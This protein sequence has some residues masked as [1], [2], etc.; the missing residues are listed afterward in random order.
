[1]S[2]RRT[3]ASAIAAAGLVTGVGTLLAQVPPHSPG[4]VCVVDSRTWCWASPPGR[5]GT[6]CACPT[7][8]GEKPGK[9][10]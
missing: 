3:I 2:N 1:M 6:R 9:L 5:P 4:T 10:Q 7:P 8:H